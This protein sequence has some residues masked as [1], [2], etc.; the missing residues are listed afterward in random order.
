M[1]NRRF[2]DK[3]LLVLGSNAG[4]EAVVNYARKY[5]AYTIV[6]DYLA[7]EASPAKLLADENVLIS[8][9]DTDTL[10]HLV[11]ER[12]I[13]AIF[14]GISEFNIL[15]AMEVAKRCGLRF[16]C[17]HE[18]WDA[19]EHKD[20]FR[21]LC[22]E[23]SVPCPHTFYSGND[24]NKIPWEEI[25]Y[26]VV[27]KPIDCGASIGVHICSNESGLKRA[28]IDSR[29]KSDAATVIIEQFCTGYEFTA[30]Y[31]VC[32]SHVALACIDNRYPVAVHEGA[33]TTIPAAR[34]YPSLFTDEYIK[35][36][37]APM[38]RL[39]ESLG[40]VNAVVFIQGLYDDATGTFSIFEAGL[41]S[42]AE[43]PSRF[44]E[45]VN[46]I[47]YMNMLV[48][49]LLL[50][51]TDYDQGREDPYLSGKCC[52]IVSFVGRRGVV[53]RVVGLDQTL[54]GVIE[55]ELRY[56]S[57]AEIPDTDTLRQIALRFVVIGDN[58][59]DLSGDIDYINSSV[60]IVDI[61]GN[62][63]VIKIDSNRVFQ[64]F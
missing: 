34:V 49:Y 10:V 62:S 2:A 13:D 4:S 14:A 43:C 44:I 20:S 42:A 51:E 6:A 29:E 11:K 22:E 1:P 39:I 35:L 52:A 64:L 16:Y 25:R 61:S 48:D 55:T 3:K 56:P 7:P 36:A 17:N 40:L 12:Q 38:K 26:P 50:G 45:R 5:G 15:Q 8:T 60:D 54:P 21:R 59:E 27:C 30:H 57:G 28:V 32:N 37:D 58:R 24:L 23:F 53:D 47:N 18:Q 31:T 46:G 33:V 19:V 9:A 63:L 41:R